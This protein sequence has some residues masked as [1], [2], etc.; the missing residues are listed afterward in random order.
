MPHITLRTLSKR[1][2]KNK[3]LLAHRDKG[4]HT[5]NAKGDLQTKY[6]V[7]SECYNSKHSD[8]LTSRL[9]Y[10]LKSY[11]LTEYMKIRD[12][13]IK[14][15]KF[16]LNDLAKAKDCAKQMILTKKTKFPPY[17]MDQ[18]FDFIWRNAI[19][20]VKDK[21]FY[22]IRANL[23]NMLNESRIS[24]IDNKSDIY[25][26]MHSYCPDIAIK[27]LAHTFYI[28][29]KSNFNFTDDTKHSTDKNTIVN[30][31]ATSKSTHSQSPSSI[32]HYILRPVDSFSGKDIFYISTKQELNK[33]IEY[34]NT[35][36][37]YKG[38]TYGNNVI[39]SE[40]IINPF[41]FKGLKF[42]M[43][44]YYLISYI[45]NKFAS[46]MLE[47]GKIIHA[48]KPY[49]TKKP[50]TKIVHDTHMDNSYDSFWPEDFTPELKAQYPAILSQ[51][52][53]ILKC[54]SNIITNRDFKQSWLYPEQKNG[55]TL[56]GVDVMVD[57]SGRV[58]LIEINNKAGFI[59]KT[60]ENNKKLEHILF[61]W[62][63]ETILKPYYTKNLQLAQQHK[64]YIE[65]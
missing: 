18:Q 57:A 7:I 40:Y 38:V 29:E 62:I 50:F 11:N 39:A 59:C 60:L 30:S 61:D 31:I 46:F 36:K 55:F 35:H 14:R 15:F 28:H 13:D 26:H 20:E 37:N 34:Y 9:R 25:T 43:R 64:T 19:N 49:T 63:N 6:F 3:P 4:K 54:V 52:K 47:F 51:I 56:L 65:L 8:L 45:N 1:T 44:V 27:H 32:Q 2:L 23:I 5:K 48:G 24:I 21:R 33:A 22:G 16:N 10:H 42:H 53:T 58:Y 17:I 12:L 41:L